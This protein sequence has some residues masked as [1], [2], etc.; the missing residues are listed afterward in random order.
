MLPLDLAGKPDDID[1]FV[2]KAAKDAPWLPALRSNF[3]KNIGD[4]CRHALGDLGLTA[5]RVAFDELRFG[6]QL[7][8]EGVEIV[9]GYDPLMYA[10]SVKTRQE[11]GS[12]QRATRLNQMAIERTVSSWSRGMSWRE[13][14]QVYHQTAVEL[15]GFVRDPGAMVWGHP[16]GGDAAIT[17]QT[18]LEDF[19]VET[20]L[21]V[22][23]DCH[24]T[25]DSYCWDGGKTWVVDSEPSIEAKKIARATEEVAS[26]LLNAMRPGIKVSELQSRGRSVFRKAGVPDAD[27]AIIFFHGL[28]LSHMDLEQVSSVGIPNADWALEEGMVVPLHVLYPGDENSRMW[29]EEVA[30]VT[31]DGAVPFFSWGQN[32]LIG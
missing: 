29:I 22:L 25:L 23:F 8:M 15:G 5:G 20:G 31:T 10:R 21:H 12:L 16:R 1:R 6:Y 32:P 9:D 2:P 3:Y 19:E 30:H 4:A 17:L 26:D 28:G 14:N 24:G 13:L 27:S 7:G 18:G 11:I